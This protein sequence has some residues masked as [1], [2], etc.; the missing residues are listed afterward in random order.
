VRSDRPDELAL[1]GAGLTMQVGPG[2]I[3]R[4]SVRPRRPGRLELVGP[5]TGGRPVLLVDVGR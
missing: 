1:R 5:S 4:F 2:T 3:V